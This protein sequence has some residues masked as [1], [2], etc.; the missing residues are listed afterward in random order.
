[1]KTEQAPLHVVSG[2]NALRPQE[3]PIKNEKL[4]S[5]FDFYSIQGEVDFLKTYPMSPEECSFYVRENI[6]RFL[7][8]FV[9]KVP[10]TKIAYLQKGETFDFAGIPV[11]KS[12]KKAADLAG[13]ESREQAEFEGFRAIEKA[14]ANGC[15]KAV[16]VSPSKNANYGFV[17]YFEKHNSAVHEYILRYDEPIG[18]TDMSKDIFSRLT[19]KEGEDER[20]HNTHDFLRRPVFDNEHPLNIEAVLQTLDIGNEK[21]QASKQFEVNVLK[22]VDPLIAVYA[23]EIQRLTLID[24]HTTPE[25]FA[26]HEKKAGNFLAAIYNLAGEV[27]KQHL[28][29]LREERSVHLEDAPPMHNIAAIADYF[30]N[31]RPAMTSGGSCPVTQELS[32]PFSN[33]TLA[34]IL[35]GGKLTPRDFLD[36]L[37]EKSDRYPDYECP[38]CKT[39][40]PGEKKGDEG[41]W[42]THCPHCKQSINCKAT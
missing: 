42:K 15:T 31:I 10:Y 9:G 29:H 26:K 5:I 19:H 21:I 13:K 34:K 33:D 40:L 23:A 41:S 16:W 39:M 25:T 35:E 30:A 6:L 22:Y 3:S 38:N 28:S 8:E 37:N 27:V 24:K 36:T 7:G 4:R 11:A 2:N 20:L 14:F 12:Y 1:M 32:N 17:F 18:S